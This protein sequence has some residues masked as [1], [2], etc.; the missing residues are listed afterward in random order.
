MMMMLHVIVKYSM[1]WPRRDTFI[2][3]DKLLVA[4]AKLIVTG[5]ILLRKFDTRK[6][7]N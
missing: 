4:C 2:E 1:F 7:K 6:W 5:Y 3:L